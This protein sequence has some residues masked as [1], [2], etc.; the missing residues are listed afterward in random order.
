MTPREDAM[1]LKQITDRAKDVIEKRGGTE[2]LKQD[3]AELKR[4][5]QGQGTLKDKAR[6][7]ADALKEPD[8]PDASPSTRAKPEP[9]ERL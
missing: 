6:R 3:A 7:A 9:A 4:I 2:A 8:R 5:A 1:N